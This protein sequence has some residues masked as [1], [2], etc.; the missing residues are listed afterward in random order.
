MI[1]GYERKEHN[2]SILYASISV[3]YLKIIQYEK[4]ELP[5]NFDR[6]HNLIDQKLER[7]KDDGYKQSFNSLQDMFKYSLVVNNSIKELSNKKLREEYMKDIS[8]LAK[9]DQDFSR[10]LRSNIQ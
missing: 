3:F 6:V 8:C 4:Q 5:L 9:L 1:L 7:L 10:A 2:D